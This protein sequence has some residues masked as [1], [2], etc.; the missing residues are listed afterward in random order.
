MRLPGLVRPFAD[1]AV[2][3]PGDLFLEPTPCRHVE[4]SHELIGAAALEAPPGRAL[5]VGAG[6]CREIPLAQLARR[7]DTVALQDQDGD[8]LADAVASLGDAE[9]KATVMTELRDLT[10]IT[11]A[12]VAGAEQALPAAGSAEHAIAALIELV[13]RASFA[14][15]PPAPVW[16]LVVASCVGSQLHIRALQEMTRRYRERFADQAALLEQSAAWA[17][18]M[19]RLS[20]RLQDAFIDHLLGLVAPDGRLY[21][22]DTVQVG[23]LY[24]RLTGGW[25]TPGWY[26]M[27]RE[28]ILAAMLPAAARPLHGGQWPYVVAPPSFDAAGLVYNVH[29]VI[30]RGRDQPPTASSPAAGR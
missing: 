25:R 18:A 16:D 6:A 1:G 2:E 29:A 9:V 14:V 21:L 11:A 15:A 20:W 8:A 4:M 22:A 24:L 27:T 5:V 26:R 13:D 3:R 30:L 7:F 23:M 17:D 12:L 28:R 10:G 19:L